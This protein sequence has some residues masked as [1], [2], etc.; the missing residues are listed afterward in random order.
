MTFSGGIEVTQG[1]ET[2]FY[3]IKS[4]LIHVSAV[5]TFSRGINFSFGIKKIHNV[6]L[7]ETVNKLLS[8]PHHKHLMQKCTFQELKMLWSLI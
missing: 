8:L 4:H 5:K 7:L 2:C 3:N 1:C 6:Q